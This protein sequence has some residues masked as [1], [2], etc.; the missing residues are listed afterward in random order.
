MGNG[1]TTEMN[2]KLCQ[3][4]TIKSKQWILVKDSKAWL[5]DNGRD[6][7][8]K[9]NQGNKASGNSKHMQL[10]LSFVN[11]VL[12][13]AFIFILHDRFSFLNRQLC[14]FANNHTK[15]H[16]SCQIRF[17]QQI[18]SKASPIFKNLFQ[19]PFMEK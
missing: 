12:N 1:K 15:C 9:E 16:P 5:N 14:E 11:S 4:D 8:K 19:L 2:N 10:Q 18:K 3:L 13:S 6:W 17:I 7:I